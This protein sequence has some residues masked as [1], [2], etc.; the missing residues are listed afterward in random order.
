MLSYRDR[1]KL[2]ND[3]ETRGY[4]VVAGVVPTEECDECIKEFRVWFDKFGKEATIR[5][6][7]IHQY[8]LS[9][10]SAA[11]R[12]R[13]RAKPVFEAIWGTEKLLSSTD[14]IAIGE[15]PEQGKY[16]S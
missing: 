12:L 3:L 10:S 2:K 7:L 15:P 13:L 16:T 8:K 1:D 11:W 4:S 5:R 6:S 14:G 9:H